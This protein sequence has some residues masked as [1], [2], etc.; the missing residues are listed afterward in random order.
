MNQELASNH[1]E[2]IHIATPSDFGKR[3]DLFLAEKHAEFSRSFLQKTII[4]GGVLVNG[5]VAAKNYKVRANDS[6]HL[7]IVEKRIEKKQIDLDILDM[8]DDFIVINKKPGLTV[9]HSNEITS[10]DTTVYDALPQNF[11]DLK[12]LDRHGLV[13]RLDKYTSGLL[14]VARNQK[15]VDE[16]GN[17]FKNRKVGKTYLCIVHGHSEKEG[18]IFLPIS[19]HSTKRDRMTHLSASGK[20]ALT[21]YK[22]IDY[23]ED[24]SLVAV[25]IITGRTHQI[26]VHMMAKGH[27][28]V[29]DLKYG[30]ESKLISRQALHAWKLDLKLY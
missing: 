17:L 24:F 25:K 20:P 27:Q 21:L 5:V 22:T 18:R 26:R 2:F 3:I 13:H 8:Q 23:Y 15:T 14:L 1:K 16:F 12:N 30:R 10:S 6:V 28:V 9:C 19:R 4:L 11:S 7:E 29:S